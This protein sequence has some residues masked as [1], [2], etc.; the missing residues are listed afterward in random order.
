MKVSHF[1]IPSGKLDD[2][3]G[4]LN[5][6]RGYP[7]GIPEPWVWHDMNGYRIVLSKTFDIDPIND[8]VRFVMNYAGYMIT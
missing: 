2:A 4:L 3:S 7:F 1:F 8:R 5:E 6:F